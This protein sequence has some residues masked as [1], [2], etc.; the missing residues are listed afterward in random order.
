MI[1]TNCMICK[2]PTDNL[3]VMD[4]KQFWLCYD[5]SFKLLKEL[6]SNISKKLRCSIGLIESLGQ[7]QAI[8]ASPMK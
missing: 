6:L 4:K 8:S 7:L 5:C 1:S 3:I 2:E